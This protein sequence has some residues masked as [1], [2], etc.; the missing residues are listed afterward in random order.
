MTLRS[1]FFLVATAVAAVA[2]ACSAESNG[3]PS[4]VASAGGADAS[5]GQGG[6]G[7]GGQPG[8]GGEAGQGGAAGEGGQT[9]EG[10]SQQGGSAGTAGE[11]A[12]PPCD[13]YWTREICPVVGATPG[14]SVAMS[15]A[16][17]ALIITETLT[18]M[19]CGSSSEP[20]I[21]LKIAQ[22]GLEGDFEVAF[23]IEK[24]VA[25]SYGAGVRAFVYDMTD[26]KESA[27]AWLTDNGSGP[28]MKVMVTHAGSPQEEVASTKNTSATFTFKRL[29]A[30]VTVLIDAGG[31]KKTLSGLLT[32]NAMRVGIGINGP[33]E[34]VDP[35]ASSSVQVTGFTVTAGGGKVKP[36]AFDCYS[37][38]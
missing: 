1:A 20:A 25:A 3:T 5:A 31:D 34:T 15:A 17:G 29:G 24:F 21:P 2:A 36:D 9:G 12:G 27:E 6:G 33:Y 37:V 4:P 14:A 16:A 18:P 22:T 32:N 28:Q 30:L 10:G 38:F 7:S 26:K 19:L 13:K 8:E 23:T 11:D 35:P